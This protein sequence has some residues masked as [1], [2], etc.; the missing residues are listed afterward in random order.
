MISY[1]I[2]SDDSSEI[3]MLGILS[4]KKRPPHLGRY[5][6]EKL[7]RVDVPTTLI[8]ADVKRVP[9]R[10]DFFVRSYYGDI[11]AA[12]AREIRRFIT[13]S[14]LCAAIGHAHW[15][16]VPAHRGEPAPEKAPLP[17]DPAELSRHVKSL[18]HFLDADLVGIC[19]IP[20]YA[21]YSHDLKGVAIEA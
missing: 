3:P 7:K 20:E 1:D 2:I 12:A 21:W 4:N 16:L 14:P 6:M 8:T 5:P 19:E 11:G 15:K 17:D 13:K 18:C 10:A 9:K